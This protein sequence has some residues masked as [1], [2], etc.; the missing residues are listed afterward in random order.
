MLMNM[1]WRKVWKKLLKGES[2]D[3]CLVTQTDESLERLKIRSENS[4]FGN[5]FKNGV[6]RGKK[7][8]F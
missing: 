2:V 1:L 3:I 4:I 5:A 7:A 8:N 6:F